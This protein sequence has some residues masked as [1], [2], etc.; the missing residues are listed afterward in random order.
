MYEIVLDPHEVADAGRVE[1]DLNSGPIRVQQE[2]IDWGDAQIQAYMADLSVGSTPVDYRLPNRTVTIPLGLG[3]DDSGGLDAAVAA[4]NQKVALFQREGGWLKRQ[5]S[6]GPLYADVVNATLHLPD[7]WRH[8][9]DVEPDVSLVLECLPDFYGDEIT[10]AAHSETVL[11]ALVFTESA[12]LGDHPGRLRLAVSEQQGVNQS[13]LLF[14]VRAR[15]YDPTPTARLAYAATA[16]TPLD[17]ATVAGSVVTHPNLSANWTPVLSTQAAGG[18]AHM[19]HAG[20]YRV[21]ARVST[22]S[23]AP[24]ALRLLYDIGDFT[25]AEENDAV[26]IPTYSRNYL[27]DLGEVRIDRARVGEHRWQGVVQAK[28][29]RGGENISIDRL[30]FQPL[31]EYATLLRTRAAGDLGLSSFVARDEFNQAAG[32]LGGKAL[33]LGG[34]WTTSGAAGDFAV[35][36]AGHTLQRATVSDASGRQALVTGALSKVAARVDLKASVVDTSVVVDFRLLLRYVDPSNY[37]IVRALISGNTAQVDVEKYVAGAASTIVGTFTSP[38][39]AGNW[40]TLDAFADTDGT[41]AVSF[42]RTGAESAEWDAQGYDAALATGGALASGQVGIWEQHADSTAVTRNY[43]NFGVWVPTGDAVLFANQSLELRWDGAYRYDPAGVAPGPVP[44]IGDLPRIPPSG[45]EG[46]TVEFFVKG[47]RGDLDQQ[48]DSGVDDI[49]A[50][51]FY[52]PAYI[53]PR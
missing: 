8:S 45:D 48:S 14:G 25:N 44:V 2:G 29:L 1:L 50:Q 36:T 40:Y 53:F 13:G 15:N 7:K 23:A 38:V 24:P 47:S 18:G 52:R 22:G 20:S 12:I 17:Q 32:N 10:L 21:W 30:Y 41:V 27:L 31:D 33:P 3:M 16:L 34:N 19:T 43:D 46:R 11:P 37:V 4:L 28:G 9:G 5:S 51:V 6:V 42:V 49:G 26:A 35:E 39:L